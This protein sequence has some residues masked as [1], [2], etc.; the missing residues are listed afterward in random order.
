MDVTKMVIGGAIVVTALYAMART[1][2][3]EQVYY[4]QSIAADEHRYPPSKWPFI[5]TENVLNNPGTQQYAYNVV[6]QAG[7]YTYTGHNGGMA[8]TG[9]R[10]MMEAYGDANMY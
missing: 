7:A 3:M 1:R 10:Q 4:E 5:P 2:S 9:Y 8:R 6:D